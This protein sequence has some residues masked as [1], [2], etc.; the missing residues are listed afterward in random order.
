MKSQEDVEKAE[1]LRKT[2]EAIEDSKMLVALI[3]A[4]SV[5]SQREIASFRKQIHEAEV[6]L[7]KPMS[8]QSS[9]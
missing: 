7:R 8:T 1:V 5:E 3:K 2:W 6:F 9:T 4:S